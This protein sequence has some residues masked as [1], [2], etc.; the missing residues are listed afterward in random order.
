MKRQTTIAFTL[1]ELLVVIAIIAILAA[2]LFPVFAKA[3]DKARQTSCLSNQKQLGLALL[4]YVQDYDE[5]Y[6]GGLMI[7]PVING[8]GTGDMREPY[9]SQLRPYIKSDGIFA[10]PSDSSGSRIAASSTSLSFWDGSYR[11]RAL[12][13]SYAYITIINDDHPTAIFSGGNQ[14]GQDTNTGLSTYVGNSTAMP[15]STGRT[16]S[17][18][19][20]PSDTVAFAEVWPALGPIPQN[21][22]YVGCPS[23]SILTGCDTAKLAGRNP[24][25]GLAV[26]QV[27]ASCTNQTLAPTPGHV[28]N[29]AN[30]LFADGSAKY[31]FWGQIRANDYYK[32]KLIKPTTVYSP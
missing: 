3:R 22:Q 18:I 17:Q 25:S 6:P 11:A 30:Y 24:T 26:D 1:I 2:I 10:C 7:E 31:Y 9:D 21:S 27:P 5:Q 14:S 29:G 4:Q 13:R 19:D 15:P 8:G 12:I 20:Q 23:G 32:F 28:N 16:L